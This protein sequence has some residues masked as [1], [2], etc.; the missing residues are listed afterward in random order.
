MFPVEVRVAAPDDL[1]LSTAYRRPTA[2]VAVHQYRGM[3]FRDWFDAFQSIAGAVGGRPH[4]GKM[5]HLDA[6]VL[7][8]RYPRFEDFRR[9]RADVDPGGLFRNRYLDRVL[10]PVTA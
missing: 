9:V 1:W 2:Y 7:R 3:P 10:G 6:E 8:E 4:W 5:H